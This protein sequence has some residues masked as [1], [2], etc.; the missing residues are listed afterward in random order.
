MACA[1]VSFLHDYFIF[2]SLKTSF[3][4]I[5]KL[6]DF[7]LLANGCSLPIAYCV[8]G[9][10][11]HLH[12]CLDSNL[13]HRQFVANFYFYNWLLVLHFGMCLRKFSGWKYLSLILFKLYIIIIELATK[14]LGVVDCFVISCIFF[15]P[16]L[17]N[18]N[19]GGNFKRLF[20]FRLLNRQYH[21]LW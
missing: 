18:Y 17:T 8:K 2:L 13:D 14:V 21:C 6:L 4:A 15:P 7:F 10:I 9:I 11:G 3:F 19:L 5:V 16:F 20:I 12:M 1:C